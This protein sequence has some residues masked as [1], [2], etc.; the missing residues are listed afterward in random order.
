MVISTET[1]K[2]LTEF[3]P[4]YYQKTQK[5]SIKGTYFNI[6][7]VMYDRHTSDITLTVE[8]LKA[9]SLNYTRM[10]TLDIFI[11]HSIGSPSHSNQTS[12]INERNT[13]WKE[14]LKN[15]SVCT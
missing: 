12:G 5:R 9:F 10:L 13:N 8:N 1:E 15:F 4:I 2:A 6:T 11:Q 3:N 7:K 14:R